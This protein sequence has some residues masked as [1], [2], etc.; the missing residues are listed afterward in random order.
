MGGALGQSVSLSARD[1]AGEGPEAGR[2]SLAAEDQAR[3]YSMQLLGVPYAE[4]AAL[5]RCPVGTVRSRGARAGTTL[6][7]LLDAAEHAAAHAT[8]AP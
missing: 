7:Q 1:A 5:C 6:W 3:L 4:A 2:Q 8:G